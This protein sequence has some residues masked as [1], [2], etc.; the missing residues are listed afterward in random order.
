GGGSGGS[1]GGGGSNG[2]GTVP[3]NVWVNLIAKHSG[4]CLD[5]TGGPGAT[6][7][8]TQLEQ[9][10]CWGGS[11]QKFQFTA[12]NGGYQIMA[13]NSGLSL[14]VY[15]G[16]PYDGVPI[17]QYAF[18]PNLYDDVWNVSPNADGSFTFSA[19]SSGKCMD[20]TGI[21]VDDGAA[22]HQWTCWG[23]DNQKWQIVPAQ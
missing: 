18:S 23:G 4:K 12:V 14:D 13:Q 10:G 21:S 2:G 8:E 15:G 9:W 3:T 6:A 5:V 20:V 7:P 22:V 16:Y 17:I 1:G 11:N 19:V